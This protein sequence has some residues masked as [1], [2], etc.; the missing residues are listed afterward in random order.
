MNESINQ[1]QADLDQAEGSLT[2]ITEAI[3]TKKKELA[4]E[5]AEAERLDSLILL[6]GDTQAMLD[7]V[8]VRATIN[9]IQT[10]L[11][12]LTRAQS[13]AS[14]RRDEAEANLI[15][16][17][18]NQGDIA[19]HL[20][21]EDMA[22]MINKVRQ[23]IDK[24]AHELFTKLDEHNKACDQLTA[25]SKRMKTLRGEDVRWDHQAGNR[26]TLSSIHSANL[27]NSLERYEAPRIEAAHKVH[28]KAMREAADIQRESVTSSAY[29]NE[30]ITQASNA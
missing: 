15:E 7:I 14:A 18:I 29:L 30:R 10:H 3:D 16:G 4:T 13:A 19:G 2:A 6:K 9:G 25:M 27:A 8:G 28:L 17:K 22:K 11:A 26:A 1:L 24:H 23:Q 20:S 5:H 12:D 21:P